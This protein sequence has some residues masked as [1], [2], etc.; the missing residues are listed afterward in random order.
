MAQLSKT[1]TVSEFGTGRN[2]QRPL[3]GGDKSQSVHGKSMSTKSFNE[4]A[5]AKGVKTFK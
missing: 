2:K 1:V 3:A 4:L 5:R